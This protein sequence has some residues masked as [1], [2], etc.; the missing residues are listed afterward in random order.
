MIGEAKPT[1]LD[2]AHF[3]RA[4]GLTR[5]SPEGAQNKAHSVSCGWKAKELLR[6][7]PPAAP[8]LIH[9]AEV[10]QRQFDATEIRMVV[11]SQREG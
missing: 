10:T 1:P 11:V 5:N 8:R 3:F 2:Y 6:H 4:V 7:S 9:F